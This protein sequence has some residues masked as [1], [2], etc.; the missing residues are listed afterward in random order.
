MAEAADMNQQLPIEPWRMS[1]GLMP[2][3]PNRD[4]SLNAYLAL[5]HSVVSKCYGLV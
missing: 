3:V 1:A 4:L 2:V 5:F